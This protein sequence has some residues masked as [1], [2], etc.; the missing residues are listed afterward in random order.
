MRFMTLG[1]GSKCVPACS[2][3]FKDM[4]MQTS[5]QKFDVTWSHLS[6]SD[7]SHD[8]IPSPPLIKVPS[9]QPVSP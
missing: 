1:T 9:K 4:L 2:L 3:S 8:H 5:V 6:T 7:A